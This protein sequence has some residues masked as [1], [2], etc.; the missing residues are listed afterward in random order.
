[1]WGFPRF[2]SDCV[3]GHGR[4]F[5]GTNLDQ[6]DLITETCTQMM[7][8]LQQL[9]DPD[10]VCSYINLRNTLFFF[11]SLH[12]FHCFEC[13]LHYSQIKV[14]IKVVSGSQLGAVAAEAKRTRTQW[15][16]LDK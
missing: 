10:K 1:M 6:K 2:H 4:S 11:L 7:L 12:C 9:Y 16:V 5:S 3:V 14:R 8:E 13:A 15:V